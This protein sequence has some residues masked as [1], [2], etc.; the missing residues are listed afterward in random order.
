MAELSFSHFLQR[1]VSRPFQPKELFSGLWGS[2]QGQKL[3]PKTATDHSAAK[4]LGL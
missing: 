4:F 3:D 1:A 2:S